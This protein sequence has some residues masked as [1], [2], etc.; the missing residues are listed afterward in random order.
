MDRG[1]GLYRTAPDAARPSWAGVATSSCIWGST[2]FVRGGPVPFLPGHG[3]DR[4]PVPRQ[5]R[6]LYGKLV[7]DKGYLSQA[8]CTELYA[9]SLTL[10]TRLRSHR[11]P[12]LLPLVDK[13]RL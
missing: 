12:R 11:K 6:D 13:V 8:L 10:I 4:Q 9:G 2:R 3:N 7:D 1:T 5:T